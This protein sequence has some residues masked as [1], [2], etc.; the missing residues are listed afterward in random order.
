MEIMDHRG[1]V[2]MSELCHIVCLV[3]LGGIYFIDGLG[4]DLSLLHDC[5]RPAIQKTFQIS[6]A[7][8][9]TLHKQTASVELLD[10]PSPHKR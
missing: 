4:V 9:V 6:Y 2:Q 8:V 1:L 10:H 5:Q 3:E 7:L